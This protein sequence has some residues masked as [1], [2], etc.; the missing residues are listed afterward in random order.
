MKDPREEALIPVNRS[1]ADPTRTSAQPRESVGRTKLRK[2]SPTLANCFVLFHFITCSILWG[3]TYACRLI[4]QDNGA[5]FADQS[6][7]SIADYPYS[8]MFLITPLFDRFYSHRIGR[9]KTYILPVTMF[10]SIFCLIISTQMKDLV[11]EVNTTPLTVYLFVLALCMGTLTIIGESWVLTLYDTEDLKSKAANYIYIGE[12]L[13]YFIGYNIFIP[14][15]DTQ[16]LNENIFTNNP[17]TEPLVSHTMILVFS[18]IF[19]ALEFLIVLFFIKERSIKDEENQMSLLELYKLVPKH[20][21]NAHMRN[22]IFYT[23]ASSMFYYSVY[24]AFDYTLVSNGH[25]DVSRSTVTNIDSV[26]YPFVIIASYLVVYFIKKGQLV[27]MYHLNIVLNVCVGFFRY[28]AY[29]DLINNQNLTRT[30]VAR[31]FIAFFIG[32]DF[33]GSFAFGFFNL[34]VDERYGNTGLS[35]LASIR[36]QALVMSSTIGFQIME[37]TGEQFYCLVGLSLQAFFL[38]ILFPYA[39]KLDKKDP[40]LF[41]LNGPMKFS[42]KEDENPEPSPKT[43]SPSVN[44]AK[45]KDALY[46]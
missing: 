41:D 36:D 29:I 39:L 43:D 44:R 16:W 7:L 31:S 40:R 8:F 6:K 22:F 11:E 17:L 1:T 12:N 3:Y 9:S 45:P 10:L 37:L 18:S 35:C 21:C 5:S 27:R 46:E 34:I 13:G 33:T 4:V 42:I 24:E 25:M 2:L 38:V 19:L 20:F 26:A 23:F 15:N 32:C 30:I 28:I 14:L